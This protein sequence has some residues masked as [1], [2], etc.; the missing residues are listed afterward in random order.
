MRLLVFYCQK[1]TLP[2]C[3]SGTKGRDLKRE[4]KRTIHNTDLSLKSYIFIEMSN[5]LKSTRGVYSVPFRRVKTFRLTIDHSK[6]WE[7]QQLFYYQIP[8]T[9][10]VKTSR[11]MS[12]SLSEELLL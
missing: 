1:K 6:D 4:I 7:I 9:F 11:R 5:S 8:K 10:I 12:L 3:F 2:Y